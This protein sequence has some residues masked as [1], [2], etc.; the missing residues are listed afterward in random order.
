[1]SA[2]KMASEAPLKLAVNNHPPGPS[3]DQGDEKEMS[4]VNVAMN[5]E[6]ERRIPEDIEKLFREHHSLILHT[7]LRVT[8]DRMEAEDVLQILFLRL[9]HNQVAVDLRSPAQYLRRAAVNL[10]LDQLRKRK[11]QVPLEAASRLSADRSSD[12]GNRQAS[13]ELAER[14]RSGLASL[15]PKAAEIFVLRH[16]EGLSNT[17]IARLVGTSWGTVAVT[18]HRAHRRLRKDLSSYRGGRS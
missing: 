6:P 11:K 2:K 15:H 8:G 16:V 1:M 7:A 12:P 14:L 13:S 5:A 3:L 9:L 4:S 17:E 10:A 18:L